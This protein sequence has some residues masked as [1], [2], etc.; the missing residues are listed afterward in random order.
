MPD[1]LQIWPKAQIWQY[2]I[3]AEC[4]AFYS[5]VRIGSLHPQERVPASPPPPPPTPIWFQGGKHTRLRAGRQVRD[6]IQTMGQALWYSRN[7]IN[8]LRCTVKNLLQ[9]TECL[10]ND[11]GQRFSPEF[12]R[13]RAEWA[14]WAMQP[15]RPV[16]DLSPLSP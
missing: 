14:K 13:L 7:T 11:G 3:H 9:V 5:V 10:R 16:R 4:R 6:P 12:S 2:C 1:K 15:G 8:P